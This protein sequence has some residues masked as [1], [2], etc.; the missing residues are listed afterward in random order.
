MSEELMESIDVLTLQK[1]PHLL[2]VDHTMNVRLARPPVGTATQGRQRV[3]VVLE[4]ILHAQVA[5]GVG[6]LLAVVSTPVCLV[7]VERAWW[8]LVVDGHHPCR[9]RLSD[10]LRVLFGTSGHLLMCRVQLLTRLL[11]GE[12][13]ASEEIL[14]ELP[15]H[16]H[17]GATFRPRLDI[18]LLQLHGKR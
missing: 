10:E 9:C 5:L 17:A 16:R 1:R 11:L 8:R 13:F 4:P 14:K 2:L 3:D 18:V 15:S 7:V 6:R 12:L